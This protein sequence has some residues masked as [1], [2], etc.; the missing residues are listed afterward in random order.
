MLISAI[1]CCA[2]F[3]GRQATMATAA[4]APAAYGDI[5]AILDC[6]VFVF[7]VFFLGGWGHPCILCP[8][9]RQLLRV[10]VL[11]PRCAVFVLG[12]GY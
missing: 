12:A 9:M 8:N 4:A 10:P 5:D 2:R 11:G 7:F 1:R 3:T 6:F